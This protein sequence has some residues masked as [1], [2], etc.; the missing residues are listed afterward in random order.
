MQTAL[1]HAE[2]HVGFV[3]GSAMWDE[4]LI[5]AATC[6]LMLFDQVAQRDCVGCSILAK[7][8]FALHHGAT[9]AF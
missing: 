6:D 7:S 4:H 2:L 8:K 1:M 3:F 5:L 9:I